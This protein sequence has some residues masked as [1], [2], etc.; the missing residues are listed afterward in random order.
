MAL[1]MWEA[2]DPG[3]KQAWLAALDDLE[4]FWERHQ[5]DKSPLIELYAPAHFASGSKTIWSE[6]IG[7]LVVSDNLTVKLKECLANE[8]F[9]SGWTRA[10]GSGPADDEE[11]E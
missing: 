5:F 6:T 7:H 11:E 1:W 4:E 10:D 9:E 2:H 8:L 3:R